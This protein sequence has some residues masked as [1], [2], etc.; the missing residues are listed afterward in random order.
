[1]CR[2]V[3]ALVEGLPV[4]VSECR[5]GARILEACSEIQ[6]DYVVIDLNLTGMEAFAATRRIVAAHRSVR[7]LL[8]GEGDDSRLR[9]R[10]AQAGVWRY[11]L[12]ES[13]IDMRRL[14]DPMTQGSENKTA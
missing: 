4:A 3:R 7:V 1:M 5:D 12:K 2:L 6:P 11:V 14:L 10:A 8:L 9:E 13:L